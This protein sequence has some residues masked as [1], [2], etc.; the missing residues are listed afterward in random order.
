LE[1][2]GIKRKSVYDGS[3]AE[4]GARDPSFTESGFYKLLLEI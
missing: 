2:I 1:L 3:W 4:Y